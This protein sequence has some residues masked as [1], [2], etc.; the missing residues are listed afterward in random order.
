M[1]RV[2]GDVHGLTDYY[3]YLARRAEYSLQIGDLGFRKD[4]NRCL[5]YL[6]QSRHKVIAGNHDDYE[7][8][9]HWSHFLGDFGTS[10]LGGVDFFFIRG[11]RSIDYKHRTLGVDYFENEQLNYLQQLKCME[12]Y[13]TV[14]PEIVI[15]HG[16]PEDI[17]PYV[18]RFKTYDGEVLKPSSTAKHL[19]VLLNIH[20]PRLW[21]FGHYHKSYVFEKDG[22]EFRCLNELEVFDL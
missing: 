13:E 2:I 17:I 8:T 1:L 7:V 14:A 19:Q 15:S 4:Y 18:A 9:H 11:E 20:R 12:L 3:L 5:T 16:C 21:I 22:C 6:A 10:S